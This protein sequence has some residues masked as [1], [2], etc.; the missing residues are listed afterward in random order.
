MIRWDFAEVI[1]DVLKRRVVSRRS[2]DK[3]PTMAYL[4]ISIPP[5]LEFTAADREHDLP[6]S[7]AISPMTPNYSLS[8]HYGNLHISSLESCDI[9]LVIHTY[10][11]RSR[12][13]FERTRKQCLPI[14][15]YLSW[16]RKDNRCVGILRLTLTR[17]ASDPYTLDTDNPQRGSTQ[18]YDA[19]SWIR[20]VGRG[21]LSHL[22]HFQFSSRCFSTPHSCSSC[23]PFP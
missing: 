23:Q 9:S 21:N 1:D 19:Y 7:I 17:F 20:Q 6:F 11:Q 16:T 10:I 3:N 12:D 18:R 13:P 22:N 15:L 4:P 8:R 2:N 14:I 5:R